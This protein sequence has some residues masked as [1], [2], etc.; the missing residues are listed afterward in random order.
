MRLYG[1][2]TYKTIT[3]AWGRRTVLYACVSARV[4]LPL[5]LAL[6]SFP[7]LNRRIGGKQLY[8]YT[9]YLV[10]TDVKIRTY[11]CIAPFCDYEHA[12]VSKR[13]KPAYMLLYHTWLRKLTAV[14]Y[15]AVLCV[16][17]FAS[18][19]LRLCVRDRKRIS[20]PSALYR[21]LLLYGLFQFVSI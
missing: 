19:V 14:K 8:K 18:C 10:H 13:S 4:C 7:R 6:L 9:I 5:L 1:I 3:L 12:R 21:G 15:I 20:C 2:R 17:T 11:V 16:P